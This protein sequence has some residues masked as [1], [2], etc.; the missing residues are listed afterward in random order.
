MTCTAAIKSAINFTVFY[1]C[2]SKFDNKFNIWV[3]HYPFSRYWGLF[4]VCDLNFKRNGKYLPNGVFNE[5]CS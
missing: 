2:L 1:S 5:L 4:Y 3:H